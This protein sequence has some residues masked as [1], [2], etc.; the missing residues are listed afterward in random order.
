MLRPVSDWDEAYILSLP[1]ENVNLERKGT[2]KL[3][4]TAEANE[5][6]VL[7][8]LAKQLSAFANTGGGKIIYGLKDDGTIDSGGVSTQVKKGGTK[9]W[10]ERQIAVLTAYE[11]VGVCVYEFESKAA[12]SQIAPGKALYVIDVPDSDRAPHQS[13]RDSKYYVRLGSQS[14]PA[15]HKLIEDIR[16]RQKHPRVTLG[17]VSVEAQS[18]RQ[19][20]PDRSRYSIELILQIALVNDGPLKSTDTFLL[21]KP[22]QGYFDM[23]KDKEIVTRVLGTR[24][25]AFQCSLNRPMPPQSETSFRA[26]YHLEARYRGHLQVMKWLDLEGRTPLEDVGIK[27]TIFADSASPLS[28]QITLGSLGFIPKLSR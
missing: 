27:W 28:G 24:Q 1:K 10:L 26:D 25:G 5:D 23:H 22:E 9:E 20:G 21:L 8:E 3:D 15:P 6:D 11:I 18:D 13:T 2:R 17:K 7:A 4:L 16:N 14:R 12:D 19:F